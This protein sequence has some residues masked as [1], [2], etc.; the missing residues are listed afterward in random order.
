MDSNLF[1]RI[2]TSIIL[3]LF[4]SIS[5]FINS[6]IL[7]FSLI[8]ISLISY[9]EFNSLTKKIWK[10]KNN[11]V[12]FVNIISILYLIFFTWITFK[13]YENPP[14][15]IIFVILICIFSDTGGYIFGKL[16]GGKKLSK[17]SPNKTI[18]GT[19]GSFLLSLMSIIILI[20]MYKFSGNS[21][22]IFKSYK[23]MI[24]LCLVL[25]FIC[26][27]GDLCISYFKRK[28]KVKDTGSILPGHGG[29]LD[30]VDG[31]IFV[32]PAAFIINK[33]IY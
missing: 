23:S 21:I 2:I 1:N 8:I 10:K 9:I 15:E 30:R 17:I 25:S 32:L 5:L 24:L 14:I 31:L 33:I 11:I 20:L 4:L 27:L 7:L 18:S 19:V 13:S 22:Y 16:I 6:Y 29:L 26:Q 28:A 12:F 3:L